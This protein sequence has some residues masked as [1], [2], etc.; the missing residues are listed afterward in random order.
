MARDS[1]NGKGEPGLTAAN[2]AGAT[3][4]FT[5]NFV[6]GLAASDVDDYFKKQY[7]NLNYTLP[8]AETQA[9]NFDFNGYRTS[10]QGQ[11]LAATLTTKSGAWQLPIAWAPT[12]SP[13]LTSAPPVTALTT[14]A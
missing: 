4:Q 2:I 12:S 3:Y 14:T 1:I 13:S 10:S 7:I 6:G 8:I 9:L 11:E 5:D